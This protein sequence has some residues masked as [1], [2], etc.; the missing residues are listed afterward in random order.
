MLRAER[1]ERSRDEGGWFL[2]PSLVDNVRPGMALH[3]DELFGP[4]LSVVRASSYAD[5]IAVMA[6]IHLGT[7]RR[8]SA[9]RARREA[10]SAPNLLRCP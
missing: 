3:S 4:V 6:R 1:P 10:G 5:A 9:A 7:Q 8:S 2:G